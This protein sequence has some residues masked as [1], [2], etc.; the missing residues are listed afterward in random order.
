METIMVACKVCG[1][2]YKNNTG[3][4]RHI[5]EHGIPNIKEYFLM[6]LGVQKYCVVCG[7][8]ARFISSV[9]GFADTCGQSCAMVHYRANLRQNEEKFNRFRSKISL[10]VTKEWA[11]NDQTV[12]VTNMKATV[13]ENNSKMTEEERKER[14]GWM[15]KIPEAD[16]AKFISEVMLNTGCHLWWR[17]ASEE[18]K[19]L[20]Y[21]KRADTKASNKINIISGLFEYDIPGCGKFTS[22]KELPQKYLNS[23]S[24]QQVRTNKSLNKLLNLPDVI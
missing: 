16:K 15:N 5:G 13:K 18:A 3:L 11:E 6:F 21:D 22:N 12:R 19:Q 1:K 8:E 2:E 10:A 20:V 23:L 24:K 17:E 9:E 4:A 14:F 7:L